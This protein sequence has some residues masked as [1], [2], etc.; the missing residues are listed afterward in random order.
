ME[1]HGVWAEAWKVGLNGRRS[2]GEDRQ[3]QGPRGHRGPKAHEG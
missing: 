2:P 3:D 1:R